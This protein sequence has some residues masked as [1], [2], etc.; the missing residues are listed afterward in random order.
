MLCTV[1][2]LFMHHNRR[3]KPVPRLLRHVVLRIIGRKL[4]ITNYESPESPSDS[5]TESEAA[6]TSRQGDIATNDQEPNDASTTQNNDCSGIDSQQSIRDEWIQ[7]ARVVDRIFFVIF[8][9]LIVVIT[10]A[11]L[12]AMTVKGP[13]KVE[14]TYVN[15]ASG[16]DA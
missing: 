5:L 15:T 14:P 6:T 9:V 2:V 10:S 1:A 3:P 13:R 7:I 11:M 8:S 4:R 12:I 16:S